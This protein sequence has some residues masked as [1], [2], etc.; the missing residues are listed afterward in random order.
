MIFVC[1]DNLLLAVM[2]YDRYVAI[3]YPLHYGIIMREELCLCL[4]A[5]S[6]ILSWAN[7]L[8]HTLL[9]AQLSFCADN[10]IPHFFCDF[11]ALLKLSCSD[12]SLNELVIFTTGAAVV[13]FPL[14]GILFSYGHIGVSILKVPSTKGICKALST[15]GSHLSVVSLF[16][17]T[18][19]AVYFSSSSSQSHDKHIIASMMYTVVTPMLNPFI[20]SL[21]NRDMTLALG[22][23]FRKK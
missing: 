7:A 9:L 18:M 15:C 12:T 19:M 22:I 11:A 17:G 21:R 8:T 6:W 2:A 3:C 23:L 13:I 10:I 16:Y 4:L 5:G 1:I 20:Y 14:S